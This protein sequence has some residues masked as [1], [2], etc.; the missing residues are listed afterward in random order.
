[1]GSNKHLKIDMVKNLVKEYRESQLMS[2]TELAKAAD[3]SSIT[4][5]RIE[6]GY[7]CRIQT[8]RKIL[9]ALGLELTDAKKVFGST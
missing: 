3:L 1:M 5:S 9:I 7:P 6:E 4:I 8:K 2:K